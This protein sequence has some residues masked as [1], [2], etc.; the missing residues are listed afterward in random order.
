MTMYC[1]F[2]SCLPF[3]SFVLFFSFFLVF[4]VLSRPPMQCRS[5]WSG[6]RTRGKE[7]LPLD[8]HCFTTNYKHSYLAVWRLQVYQVILVLVPQVL[9]FHRSVYDVVV[10][11]SAC[12]TPFTSSPRVT[13]VRRKYWPV[14]TKPGLLDIPTL[15]QARVQRRS[16][17]GYNEIIMRR[18]ARDA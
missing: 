18:L 1:L 17:F 2:I 12:L 3:L 10:R 7:P 5:S 11:T 15:N 14:K 8:Y 4:S 6:G 16:G 9:F 13:G